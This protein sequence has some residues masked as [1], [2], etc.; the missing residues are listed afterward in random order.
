MRRRDFGGRPYT[1]GGLGCDQIVQTFGRY[2]FR[3]KVPPGAG[4]DSFVTLWPA[5]AGHDRHASL[6]EILARPG[7]EKAYLSNQYGSR[8]TH[9]TAPGAYSD[10][11]HTY[12]IEWSPSFFRVLVD[13]TARLS[14][15]H[16]SNRRKWIGFAVTSGD[17]L[18]G[19]PDAATTLPAEFQVDF[20]RV[21]S[22]DPKTTPV[23]AAQ[24]L[25]PGGAGRE[26]TAG[27]AVR[28][29][30]SVIIAGGAVAAVVILMITWYTKLRARRRL[31]PAHRA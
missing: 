20:L 17:P 27:S 28:Q 5:E 25:P 7:D 12:V 14:D 31:R 4:I 30:V 10:D 3:A 24:P 13:G 6:V 15:T 11:F 19:V 22:Y 8:A 18:T 29:L 26:A 1:T 9:V 23:T 2:E 21:Y 16:V